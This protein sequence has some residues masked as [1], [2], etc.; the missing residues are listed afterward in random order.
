[1]WYAFTVLNLLNRLIDLRS[2]D[3]GCDQL[4]ELFMAKYVSVVGILQSFLDMQPKRKIF[5]CNLGCHVVGQFVD[6]GNEPF[7]N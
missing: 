7:F 5:E 3:T 1:M 6:H 2:D 4:L